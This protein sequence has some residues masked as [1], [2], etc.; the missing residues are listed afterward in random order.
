MNSQAIAPVVLFDLDGTLVD[1]ALDLLDAL[2][3]I[4]VREGKPRVPLSAVR[5]LVSK[6]ARAMLSAA[7]PERDEAARESLLQPFLDAYAQSVVAHSTPFAGIA[8]V[9]DSIEAAG[10]RWGIVTNKPH[11]L[12]A[13]V[14]SGMGWS[15]RSAV[16]I[17]GDTLPKKKPDPDQLFFAC[18]TLGVAASDCVYVGDDERDIVAARHARMKSVA[19]LWGYRQA[20]ENPNDWNSGALAELP[21]DL[22]RPGVLSP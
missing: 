7:F 17:G 16:L 18:E 9:L 3:V 12:A 22:L 19:A 1:S 6:G 11:Y 21:L 5:S 8:E 10:S 14:V 15:G 13:A 20:H 2:N 4:V